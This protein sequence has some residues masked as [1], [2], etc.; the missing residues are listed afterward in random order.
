MPATLDRVPWQ[1]IAEVIADKLKRG[2]NKAGIFLQIQNA[3]ASR[4]DQTTLLQR[5]FL[6]YRICGQQMFKIQRSD[7]AWGDIH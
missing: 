6:G 7:K 5:V 1:R 2:M 3:A 4:R